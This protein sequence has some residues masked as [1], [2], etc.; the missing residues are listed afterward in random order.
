MYT[1]L[2]DLTTNSSSVCPQVA[3]RCFALD[4]QGTVLRWFFNDDAF[5][6]YTYRLNDQYPLSVDPENQTYS[7][8]VN[9]E[10]IY[11]SQNSSNQD[12][13]TFLSILTVIDIS[14]LQNAGVQNISCG[15]FS[16]QN[17]TSILPN[18]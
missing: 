15:G 13:F 10:I 4:L 6:V 17:R 1:G 2:I 9:T 14:N 8:R 16:I 3:F 11:V 5:A 18:G 12:V 7:A